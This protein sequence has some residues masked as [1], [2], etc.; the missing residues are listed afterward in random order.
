MPKL[1]KKEKDR[2]MLRS[3][4]GEFSPLSAT[5]V[6]RVFKARKPSVLLKDLLDG[7]E[8]L[9]T[10]KTGPEYLRSVLMKKKYGQAER[11]VTSNALMYKVYFKKRSRQF[12]EN[13]HMT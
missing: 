5:E 11:L 13:L 8:I 4:V 7:P 12:Q 6:E 3:L 2:D 9:N 10:I 1:I